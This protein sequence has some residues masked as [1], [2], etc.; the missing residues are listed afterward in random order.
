M[1]PTQLNFRSPK[2]RTAEFKHFLVT[3]T[4][5]NLDFL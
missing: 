2:E 3:N 1:R 4:G 5:N